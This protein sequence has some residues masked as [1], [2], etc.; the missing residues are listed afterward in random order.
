MST[1]SEPGAPSTRGP[2]QPG[3]CTFNGCQW[4]IVYEINT[5][6]C[7]CNSNLCN[8]DSSITTTVRPYSTITTTVRPYSTITTTVRP[9]STITTT[10]R[11]YSTTCFYCLTCPRPFDRYNTAVSQTYSPTGWCA[12]C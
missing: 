4:R 2:A 10:V 7:C 9:Y 1:S 5:Y 3:L 8:G 12:V 11:P 6:V